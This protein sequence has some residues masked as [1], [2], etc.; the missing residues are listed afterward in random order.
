MGSA[1]VGV[2]EAD[3]EAASELGSFFQSCAKLVP[4]EWA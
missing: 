3:E 1:D 2:S 4:S